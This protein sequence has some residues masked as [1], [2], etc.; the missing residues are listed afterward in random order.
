M[1]EISG[2]VE[3][4]ANIRRRGEDY[5]EGA[6]LLEAGARLGPAQISL[7]AGAGHSSVAVHRSPRVAV[8]ATG[9]ELV[10]PGQP[11]GSSQIWESNAY[12][13]IGA[14]QEIGIEAVHQR[15]GDSLAKTAE[16]IASAAEGAD[17]ILTSGGISVG[18]RDYVR[19]AAEDLGAE[20]QFWGVRAKPGQPFY[21]ATLGKTHIF[22]LPGNPVSA[23]STYTVLVR[24][25][26]LKSLG[27]SNISRTFSARISAETIKKAG[28][29]EFVRGRTEQRG[30]EV[31]VEPSGKRGSH[32]LGGLAWADCLIHFPLEASRLEPG[33]Q[34]QITLLNWRGE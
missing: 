26:L 12:G 33:E 34:V 6:P 3:P 25:A 24:P 10:E 28:R 7:A 27:A 32:M 19:R 8:L 1:I 23:L 9:D 29:L 16:A 17:F 22:G 30:A 15:V 14:L 31:W 11:L 5:P 4:G 20:K 18:D 21:F 2:Q 13:L